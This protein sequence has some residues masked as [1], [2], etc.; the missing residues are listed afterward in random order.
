MVQRSQSPPTELQTDG[1]LF[2]QRVVAHL[3]L[4]HL[5]FD[6][7]VFRTI[8]PRDDDDSGVADVETVRSVFVRIETNLESRWNAH[9]LVDNGPAYLAA[10]AD[11]DTF[12]QD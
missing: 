7:Q 12:E 5:M 1:G 6:F 11:I 4:H 3:Q 10:T 2:C 8:G 9:I